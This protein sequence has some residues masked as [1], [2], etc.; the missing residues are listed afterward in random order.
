M[1]IGFKPASYLSAIGLMSKVG[2][3]MMGMPVLC[4]LF[5]SVRLRKMKRVWVIQ[6]CVHCRRSSPCRH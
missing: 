1:E 2:I 3:A 4:M 5:R 6:Q